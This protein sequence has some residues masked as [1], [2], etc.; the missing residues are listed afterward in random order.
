MSGWIGASQGFNAA[1]NAVNVSSMRKK[2]RDGFPG[3]ALDTTRWDSSTGTAGSLTVSSGNLTIASG[4]TANDVVY[5]MAKEVFMAP[6]RLAIGLTL[7]QRIAN[8]TFY[9][10]LVS[11]DSTTQQP[12]GLNSV[13]WL[14]DGTTAT[15][16][17]YRAQ[18][19]GNTA[20][21]SAASTIPTTASAGIYEIEL[22]A[23]DVWYHGGTLDSTVIR[24]NSYRRHTGTPDPNALYRLRLRWVNGASTPASSTTAT[25]S[26]LAVQDE[27]V[28]TAEI[29]G[30]RGQTAAAQALGVSL[31]GTPIIPPG[32]PGLIPDVTT[33]SITTT[34][35]STAVTPTYGCSY[36]VYVS[37]PSVSGTSPTLDVVVQESDDSGTNWFDV[38]HFPRITATGIYY[39]PK[40]PM[41]G[42]RVR[43][44]QTVGGTSPLIARNIGR[45]Q[46]SDG[47]HPPI[48]QLI[49]RSTI[50]L[51]TLASATPSINTQGCAKAQLVVNIGAA[52]TA[53]ILQLQGS[54]DNGATWYAVG[55]TLTAVANSTVQLTTYYTN[56]Q[57][58]RAVV[59]LAGATVTAGYV[60]IKG[61]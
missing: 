53:P 45:T 8:Q 44:V 6:S 48:R 12:D 57:L 26:Y 40:L 46:F 61:F 19:S 1:E 17:K 9:V 11:V 38:Y 4:T 22:Y 18:V 28:L 56:S 39:S 31:V 2:W 10:E 50:V 16:A 14:F 49:D 5:A 58:L 24:A 55:S 54:D 52:T 32:A 20:I 27:E 23:D 51:T 42:N 7:S 21:D 29:T 25:I 3:S 43:Y 41:V 60:L 35:T 34:T 47:V 30:G 36:G 33:S 15:M 13:A 37:I 59:T